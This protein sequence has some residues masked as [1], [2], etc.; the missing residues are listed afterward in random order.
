MQSPMKLNNC[1]VFCLL[2]SVY[3]HDVGMLVELP[4]DKDRVDQM[5]TNG[6]APITF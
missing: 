4:D 6:Q 3:L 5:R 1:E 2:A